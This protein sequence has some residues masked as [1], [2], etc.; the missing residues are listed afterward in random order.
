MAEP[1]RRTEF[2]S[3]LLDA[4]S[5]ASAEIAG[6]VL[7][8]NHYHILVG[9]QNFEG[10]P[11]VLKRLHG[12]ISYEWNKADGFTGLRRVW[13]KYYYRMIRNQ[14]HYFR[15]LNYILL[16]PRKHGYVRDPYEWAWS[17]LHIYNEEKGREWL[18]EHWTKFPPPEDFGKGWD[19]DSP[20]PEHLWP[21]FDNL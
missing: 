20:T 14:E 16:N 15:A 1:A 19:D 13:Y 8:P 12:G 17:S 18:R 2:E 11:S 10:I 3:R 7:L 21:I 9:I 5:M 6:W 4:M